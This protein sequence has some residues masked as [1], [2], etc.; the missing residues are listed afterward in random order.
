MR[1]ARPTLGGEA[2]ALRPRAGVADQEGAGQRH[3]DAPAPARS[4][5][6][7]RGQEPDGDAGVEDRLA[8]AVEGRVEEAAEGGAAA[9]ARASAPSTASST[10]PAVRTAAPTRS[11]PLATRMAATSVISEADD[12]DRV[13][14]QVQRH[15]QPHDRR[16]ERAPGMLDPVRQDR[17]AAR[18][19]RGRARG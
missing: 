5:R 13:G 15:R 8:G 4:G 17:C 16:E 7:E 1:G 11:Q 12:G 19:A 10:E 6:V 14:G 2:D 3:E 18:A 9:L